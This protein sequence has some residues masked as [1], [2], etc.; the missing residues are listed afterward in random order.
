[1]S[2]LM[3]LLVTFLFVL[4]FCA[5]AQD[6]PKCPKGF[7][8]YGGRCVSQRMSDY[9]A[10]VEASGGN[11]EE[12]IQEVNEVANRQLSGEA[13]GS[14]SGMVVKGAGSL[15]LNSGSEKELVK[16]IQQKWYSGGMKQCAS[17][18][19]PKPKA[20]TPEPITSAPNCPNGICPTAP[21]FGVQT[22]NNGP[23]PLKLE[24]S[25]KTLTEEETPAFGFERDKCPVVTH[26]RIVPNQAVPPPIRVALDFDYPVTNIAT[27]IENVGGLMGGGPFTLGMHP[28]SSPISPGISPH[29]ALVV[30]VCSA[31][32]VKLT[33]EPHLVD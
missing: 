2:K 28:I 25:F 18:L 29:H 31:V 23:P 5:V 30:E 22:V 16:K 27:T 9:I 13:K 6:Q 20:K 7:Q 24:Y 15:T 8:P 17:V 33:G 11:H 1:M 32:T 21:N 19:D 26:L 3:R 14:G 10:C 12:L 4:P